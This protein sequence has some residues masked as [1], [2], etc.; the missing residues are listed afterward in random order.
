[1]SVLLPAPFGPSNPKISPAWTSND[2]PRSAGVVAVALGDVVER[3]D[4]HVPKS[5]L[6][7]AE[8]PQ[9]ARQVQVSVRQRIRAA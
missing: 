7:V 3:E 6:E 8:M 9:R 1:M 5:L 4:D 2:T